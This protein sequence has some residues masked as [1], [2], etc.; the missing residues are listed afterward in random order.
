L[1]NHESISDPSFTRHSVASTP[2]M[3]REGP[4]TVKMQKLDSKG[5]TKITNDGTQCDNQGNNFEN[6]RADVKVRGGKWFYEVKLLTY[7]KMHFGWCTDKCQIATN[8][9]TGIGNDNESWGYDG[10]SQKAWYGTNTT[11]NGRYGEYWNNGDVIGCVLDLEAKT[12]SFYRNG[13]D[14]GVA[15]TNFNVGDGM[16]PAASLQKRQKCEFNFGKTAFKY[17]LSEVFP[18]IHPL[19][20]ILTK[21]QQ[22][23]LE[24]LY[25]KY[26]GMGVNLKE[27]T[28]AID[29]IRGDG[30]LHYGQDLGITDDKDP[31]LL[32]I[33]W[34]LNAI[35][36]IW[37]FQKEEFCGGWAI[38][39]CYNSET[40][41]KK[42]RGWAE[43]LKDPS[44]F[45]LFYHFVFDYLKEDKKIIGME[46]AL[47]V[48]DMIGFTSDL[49]STRWLL[50]PKW[51]EFAKEKKSISR[52]TWRLFLAFAE[53]YPK[54]L[55]S[56]DADGCWPSMIDE[57]V[58]KVQGNKGKEEKD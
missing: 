4:A 9:N 16:Y 7:G 27:S 44:K 24:K 51:V 31:L 58:E 57:F 42:A 45:K 1:G 50:M 3:N 56:Y 10:S 23:A 55:S 40:M 39:G 17:P 54:D 34:K 6:V 15:F 46:E 43:E 12:M 5:A 13:K 14:M 29:S 36:K 49:K 38:H 8:A 25:E 32:I 33:A 41:K 2:K 26:R 18:D 22:T 37:E 20:L 53:Q 19:H 21:D 47:T 48:W 11:N 28:E 30:L 52:D 35:R